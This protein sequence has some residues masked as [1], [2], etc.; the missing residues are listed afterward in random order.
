MSTP[1]CPTPML[2][3]IEWFVFAMLFSNSIAYNYWDVCACFTFF[4]VTFCMLHGTRDGSMCMNETQ[5]PYNP[6][7]S[8]NENVWFFI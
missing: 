5:G 6:N 3:Y 8:I 4:F 7:I 1:I 2:D